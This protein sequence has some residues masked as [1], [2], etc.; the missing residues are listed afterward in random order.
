MAAARTVRFAA[1]A[2]ADMIEAL[3][4]SQHNFGTRARTR[5]AHLIMSTVQTLA[6][7]PQGV[8]SKN[9]SDLRDQLWSR[10]LRSQAKSSGVREPRH[11]I[12]YE[13]DETHVIIARVLHEAMDFE[14][15]LRRP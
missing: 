11:V 8:G 2:E 12:F 3:R 5:Y 13:F 7:D 14:T 4:A 1:P 6:R 10:H 15:E 9:R